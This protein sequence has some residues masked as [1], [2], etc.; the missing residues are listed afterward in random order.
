LVWKEA[1]EWTAVGEI[2]VATPVA[3]A[4]AAAAG[5]LVEEAVVLEVELWAPEAA[6]M[7]VVAD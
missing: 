6:E 4:A 5:R 1:A 2:G 3:V 7:V